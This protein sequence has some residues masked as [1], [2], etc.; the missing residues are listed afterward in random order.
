MEQNNFTPDILLQ[1]NCPDQFLKRS[2]TKVLQPYAL[3]L[4]RAEYK[5]HCSLKLYKI[6]AGGVLLLLQQY[7]TLILNYSFGHGCIAMQPMV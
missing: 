4:L 2:P 6:G 7:H 3:T 5:S 1:N